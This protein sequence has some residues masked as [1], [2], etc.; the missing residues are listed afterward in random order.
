MNGAIFGKYQVLE[1]V[2][3]GGMSVVYRGRDTV[4]GREVAIKVMHPFMAQKSDAKQRFHREA[5]A[6]AKLSHP[7]ILEVYDYSGEDAQQAYIVMEFI[8]GETMSSFASRVPM[9]LP[10]V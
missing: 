8:R 7:N 1:E 5:M 2:G 3:Q 9:D 4:L 6:V 10:E